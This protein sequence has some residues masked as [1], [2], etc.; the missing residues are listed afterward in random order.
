M[1]VTP[2]IKF[3][4]YAI[5]SESG[6]TCRADRRHQV[7]I[8]G[9]SGTACA[10][11]LAGRRVLES[12]FKSYPPRVDRCSPPAFPHLGPQRFVSLCWSPCFGPAA[13]P[14]KR[15]RRPIT[16]GKPPARPPPQRPPPS[17]RQR[18]VQHGGCRMDRSPQPIRLKTKLRIP[19]GRKTRRRP[20]ANRVPCPRRS[21]PSHW[22]PYKHQQTP[23]VPPS[24]NRTRRRPL[25]LKPPP[26][27]RI[28]SPRPLRRGRA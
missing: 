28:A 4:D 12:R 6:H 27:C 10:L 9:G 1:A 21:M 22:H 7:L 2:A 23:N 11:P 8:Q 16:A 3:N 24:R 25:S 15:P 18:R 14:P 20:C 19:C 17:A 13:R 5:F 26:S